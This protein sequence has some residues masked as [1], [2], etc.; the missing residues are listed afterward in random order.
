MLTVRDDIDRESDIPS[1]ITNGECQAVYELTVELR[2]N[3][4]GNPTET[5][6]NMYTVNTTLY[7]NGTISFTVFTGDYICK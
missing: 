4:G 5:L 7:I 1:L 2:D 6:S 3:I